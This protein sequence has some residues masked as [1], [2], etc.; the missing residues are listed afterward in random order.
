MPVS[1]SNVSIPSGFSVLLHVSGSIFE[2]AMPTIIWVYH[3]HLCCH[4]FWIVCQLILS[5]S[6][7]IVSLLILQFQRKCK[8]KT[9]IH[10]RDCFEEKLSELN[11]FLVIILFSESELPP[12]IRAASLNSC[13][14]INS[15]P[16]AIIKMKNYIK[17]QE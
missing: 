15:V 5:D 9:Y 7:C 6:A 12:N 11:S 3:H 1:K 8:A 13:W 10:I 17:T 14:C 4:T 2:Y 16:Y